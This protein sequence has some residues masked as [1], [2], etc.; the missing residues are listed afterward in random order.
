MTEETKG[1]KLEDASIDEIKIEIF[2]L[3]QSL[4]YLNGQ[5]KTLYQELGKRMSAEN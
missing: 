3:E 1:K 2:D 4:K 5:T